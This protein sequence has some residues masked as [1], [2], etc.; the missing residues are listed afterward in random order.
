VTAFGTLVGDLVIRQLRWSTV[1]NH[2]AHVTFSI[3][4]VGV[5]YD[6][7]GGASG[8]DVFSPENMSALAVAVILLP[9][10]VNLSFYLEMAQSSGF[11]WVDAGLTARWEAIMGICSAAIALGTVALVTSDPTIGRAV[12]W[13]G[14]LLGGAVLLHFLLART[15]LADEL[16]FVQGLAGAV[17]AEV[18]IERSFAR[19][20][21]LAGQLVP[22]EHMGFARY[23]VEKEEMELVADTATT[24]RLRFPASSGLTGEAVSTGG[25]VVSNRFTTRELVL[26]Q[27]EAAGS[28]ILIPL[29][30]GKDLVGL[31]SVRHSDASLYRKPDA[32]LINLLAPQLALSLSLTDI[33]APMARSSASAGEAVGRL[34]SSSQAIAHVAGRVVTRAEKA[35]AEAKR[36]A[37]VVEEA[38]DSLDQLAVGITAA[39]TAADETKHVTERVAQKANELRA[40]TSQGVEQLRRLTEIIEEGAEE[41]ARLR[42]AAGEV[43]GFSETIANIANQTNLLALNAT[44]EASRAGVHG[45]GF[46][47]VAE[48]VRKLADESGR[49]ARNIGKSAQGTRKVIDG[50]ASVLDELR[51]QLADLAS[52]SEGWGQRLAE[53][54]QTADETRA[55]GDR[56]ARIPRENLTL[57]EQVKTTLAGALESARASAAEAAELAASAGDQLDAIR[58]LSRGASDLAELARQLREGA[59]FV[60]G[61][62]ASRGPRPK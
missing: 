4:I 51:S 34:E 17:A 36:A 29:Y 3:G 42:D 53:I 50:A 21:E 9:V 24:E 58:D 54:V 30:H 40:T 46:A 57:S 62:G 13:G 22:W 5:V 33:L 12:F 10:V 31:W 20:Q 19:I 35:E 14:P 28:E 26:P 7:M 60:G 55:A 43:E 32:D 16:R 44:I 41:V 15:V 45:R 11:A 47:V 18:S 56:M 48:E 38:V 8:V 1:V 39:A 49:A 6:A 37:D 2:V 25:P 23:D 52:A 27:G 59:R 61:D